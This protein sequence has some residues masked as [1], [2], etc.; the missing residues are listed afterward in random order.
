M[1]LSLTKTGKLSQNLKATSPPFSIRVEGTREQ[2][3]VRE[4]IS[5]LYHM[6]LS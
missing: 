5:P 1:L 2:R 3:P 6:P 4:L